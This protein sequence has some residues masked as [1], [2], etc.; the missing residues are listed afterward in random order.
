M[1]ILLINFFGSIF[2]VVAQA[3]GP[4]SH[5]LAALRTWPSQGK[6]VSRQ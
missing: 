2:I 1:K 5:R 3:H 4:L 6:Y